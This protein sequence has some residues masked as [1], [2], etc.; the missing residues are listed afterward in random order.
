MRACLRE[1]GFVYDLQ[2]MFV[3][4]I[5]KSLV[6]KRTQEWKS[7]QKMYLTGIIGSLLMKVLRLACLMN[8]HLNEGGTKHLKAFTLQKAVVTTKA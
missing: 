5:R 3:Y 1:G 8:P 6:R 7:K 2:L 4:F